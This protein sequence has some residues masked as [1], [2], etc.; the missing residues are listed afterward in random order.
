MDEET[1]MNEQGPSNREGESEP[2]LKALAA[3]I[4]LIF[5]A[6]FM[7]APLIPALSLEFHVS[8]RFIGLAIPAYMLPYGLSTLAYGPLSDRIGRRAVLLTLLAAAVVTTALQSLAG[9]AWT[10]IAFRVLAGLCAGG[11]A[12]IALAQVADL[13]PY[14]RLGR[15]LGW[16][17]GAIAGGTAFGSTVGAW[18][19]PVIGWRYEF[20]GLAAV[21][22]LVFLLVAKHRHLLSGPSQGLY[23]ES[24]ILEDYRVLLQGRRASRTYA[25]IFLNGIFHSGLFSWLGLYLSERYHL[26]DI[27]IGNAL[28]GYGLP[29]MLLGPLLGRL[30]DRW[31]RKWVIPAGLLL[32]ATCAFLLAPRSPLWLVVA[33]TT[34][35]SAGFDLTQP[36]LAGIVTSLDPRRRGQAIGLNAFFLFIGYG[37]GAALFQ[38]LLAK[39]FTVALLSFAGAQAALALLAFRLFKGESAVKI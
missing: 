13:Y 8:P 26:D 21:G 19:N 36:P 35:L 34:L 17:F 39:G 6:A 23:A 7:V 9:S 38:V 24:R 16:I 14:Q 33:V 18:L 2:I 10:M 28:L 22:A 1:R 12:P 20:L 4:F 3:S 29:G 30:A 5:F 37:T 15:A 32:S 27:G 31:G 11:I 25:Y